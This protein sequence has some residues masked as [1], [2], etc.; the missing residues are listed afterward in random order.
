MTENASRQPKGI[1]AGGQFAANAHAETALNLAPRRPELDGWPESLP[2]PEVS[3]HMGDDNVITTNI[4]INGE[5]A[6][7]V[8]NPGDDAHSIETTQFDHPALADSEFFGAAENWAKDKHEQMVG[9]LRAEMHAAVERSRA[10]VLAKSTGATPRLSDAELGTLVGLNQAA[11]YRAHRDTELACAAVIARSILK[12]RPDAHHI[13]LQID[14]ADNGEFVSGAII[15]DAD[16]NYISSLSSYD[17]FLE[18]DEQYAGEDVAGLF[19]ELEAEP[20]RAHWADLN[21][22]IQEDDDRF[23]IDL[24]K[25]AAWTGADE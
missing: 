2:E 21:I 8:W 14:S 18:E 11:A 10:R 6:F 17:S 4:D 9:E 12:D 13:G 3:F 15:Y 25:A 20:D 1:P 16:G 24:Q 5:P 23:T 22:P 7:E 19:S